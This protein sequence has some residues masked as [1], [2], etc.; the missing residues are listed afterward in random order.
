MG[1]QLELVGLS[2]KLCR[3]L[4]F[5]SMKHGLNPICNAY[6]NGSQVLH[7]YIMFWGLGVLFF[8]FRG[9][10]GPDVAQKLT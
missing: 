10:R 7:K 3:V 2:F 5:V 8:S 9:S 1:V 6:L 4:N